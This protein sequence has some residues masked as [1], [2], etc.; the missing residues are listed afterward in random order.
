MLI[1]IMLFCLSLVFAAIAYF[2]PEKRRPVA[3]LAIIM[4][5]LSVCLLYSIKPSAVGVL[6]LLFG[7]AQVFNIARLLD[8]RLNSKYLAA[9]FFRGGISILIAEITLLGVSQTLLPWLHLWQLAVLQAIAGVVAAGIVVGRYF[10]TRPRSVAKFM[11][12]QELPSI[13]VLVP[14]RNDGESLNKALSLLVANDYPKL[15]IL[16]LDDQSAGRQV[17]DVIKSF[18]HAGVR[19]VQGEPPNLH[20][21]S[22]NLAYKSLANQAS[23]D[24]LVFMGVDVRLGPGS[25]RALVHY[26]IN[27][28]KDMISILP[29]RAGNGYWLGFFTPLRYFREFVKINIFGQNPPAL[30]TMWLIKR[31][32]YKSIGGIEGVA[33]KVVPEHY[34]AKQLSA[35]NR[36]GFVRTNDY[37]QVE[38]S[39]T[40]SQQI[41]TSIRVL[42]PSLHRRIEWNLMTMIFMASLYF[43]P[44]VQSIWLGL[45]GNHGTVF[46]LS[47]LAAGCLTLSHIVITLVTNPPLWPFAVINFPY[48]V[49]QDIVLNFISMYRYEFGEVYWKGRNICLPV[50]HVYKNLPPIESSLVQ[51][52]VL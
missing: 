31:E 20:W 41:D 19:F 49:L 38:T 34:F 10:T 50:M 18:A 23:G 13:S 26:A 30:S 36:Y 37:L 24:W 3:G 29:H 21:L 8:G 45:N 33:R 28:D 51:K 7:L 52:F 11:S 1:G 46:W 22:K 12:D 4:H 5:A 9:A 25:L 32:A 6:F 16:A 48:L 14:A 27:H 39:K 47:L 2:V 35:N 44:F 43:M 40:L 42:Y 17:S 15:E